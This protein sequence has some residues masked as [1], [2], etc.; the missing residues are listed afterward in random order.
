VKLFTRRERLIL[1]AFAEALLP[2][3]GVLTESP[4]DIG[5]TDRIERHVALYSRNIRAVFRLGLWLVEGLCLLRAGTCFTRLDE[6]KRRSRLDRWRESKVYGR[7]LL[8]KLLESTTYA[9]YYAHPD[10]SRKIG[11][12]PPPAKPAKPLPHHTEAPDR[13]IFLE[14]DVCVVGSGAGGAVTAKELAEKGRSV[15]ILEEGAYYGLKDFGRDAFEIVEVAYHNAGTQMTLGLPCIILPTGRAVGGT[16]VINSG[17]C[18]RLPDKVAARWRSEFGL[19]GL[20]SEVLAPYFERVERHLHVAPVEEAV[21]GNN[22]KIFRRGLEVRGLKGFPLPRNAENC[23]GSGMCCFGCPTDAK[24]SV[25]LSYV[26]QA[27]ARGAKLFT[28]CRAEKII[29]KQEHGGEVIGRFLDASGRPGRRIHVSA[30]AVVLAAG[31]LKTPYLLRSNGIVLHNPHVGRHLTIHPTGKIIGVFDEEVR[32]WEGVPQ[33]FGY[34]G[35]HDEGILFEGAFMPPSFGSIS[36][37]LPAKQ[38]K[39]LMEGYSHLA[40]FGFL[41]S[42]EARGWIRWLPNGEPLVYYSIRRR[43]LQKYVKGIRFLT[44][45]FLAAGA[46]K[47][48][49]G[50]KGLSPITPET[51]LAPFDAHTVKRTELDIAAFHPLGT[52]RMAADPD[53]GVVDE[54]GQVHGVNNL[55]IADGSIFPSSLGVNPQETIMAFANRTADHIDQEIG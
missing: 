14:V 49:T 19:T 10:V 54:N 45:T 21:L 16:T 5:L 13:D 33:G 38:H 28:R 51:G 39:E 26:P 1:N 9:A 4:A 23:K 36:L 53:Q 41:I 22:S 35:L 55:F 17:T 8:Y 42:D 44:E 30:K 34:D 12:A 27:V 40:S 47:I 48:F 50:I 3:T 52:C 43:E 37:S 31:T 7:R 18:F 15:A 46:K 29:S 20:T 25:N 32:A 11:Y 2:P 6:E 24:Q